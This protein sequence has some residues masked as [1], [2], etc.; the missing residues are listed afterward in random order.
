MRQHE[1]GGAGD[2][3]AKYGGTPFTLP[4][5][6]KSR[7]RFIQLVRDTAERAYYFPRKLKKNRYM[8]KIRTR[9]AESS[10]GAE[11]PPGA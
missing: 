3:K 2:Y 10:D 1:W 5:F 4:E 9:D 7:Y 6:R 8:A 11:R